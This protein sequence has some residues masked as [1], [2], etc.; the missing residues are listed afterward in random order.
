VGSAIACAYEGSRVFFHEIQA[1]TVP[2]KSG[3]SRIYSERIDA[4]RALR[5]AAV[6]EKHVGVRFSDQDV[7]VNVSGG[8]RLT[9]TGIDLPLALALYSARINTAL[10]NLLVS[11]GEIALSGE[12][13]S[14]L[15]MPKRLKGA[16]ELNFAY[17]AGFHQEGLNIKTIASA[18]IRE[19]L[20]QILLINQ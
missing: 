11:A 7:Y 16:N 6:L 19:L 13:R 17:F 10:P 14:A 4:G 8:I 1:L 3:N 18:N 12:V 2:A 20:K 9:E 5:I 15:Q